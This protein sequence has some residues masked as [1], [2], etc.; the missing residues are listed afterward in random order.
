MVRLYLLRISEAA[1]KKEWKSKCKLQT[2]L[3]MK[4]IV[5]RNTLNGKAFDDDELVLLGRLLKKL[6]PPMPNS[7]DEEREGKWQ[8]GPV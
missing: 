1:Y 3:S 2:T 8:L 7:C 6:F 4:S 5:D